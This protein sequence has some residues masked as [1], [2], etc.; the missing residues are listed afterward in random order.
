MLKTL[1]TLMTPKPLL[2]KTC[3][4]QPQ[5]TL[6]LDLQ[7]ARAGF[8]S[9]RQCLEERRCGGLVLLRSFHFLVESKGL[10]VHPFRSSIGRTTGVHVFESLSD[11]NTVRL[12]VH[13]D[14]HLEYSGGAQFLG[15]H[16]DGHGSKL[17]RQR[18]L[19]QRNCNFVE[20]DTWH[21]ESFLAIVR[22]PF[23]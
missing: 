22:T 3:P 19:F 2:N 21:H 4:V 15:L 1:N 5:S 12:A 18:G 16:R 17:W 13:L 7:V 20:V 8:P 14:K 6:E 10:R 23:S 11:R 9:P